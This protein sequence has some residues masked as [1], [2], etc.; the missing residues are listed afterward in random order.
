MAYLGQI[1]DPGATPNPRC[2]NCRSV[3][4]DVGTYPYVILDID[5]TDLWDL[6]I[7]ARTVGKTKAVTSNDGAAVYGH[8]L[9]YPHLISNSNMWM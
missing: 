2:A 8:I 5:D 7:Y 9:P 4:R 1:I 3:N 6:V